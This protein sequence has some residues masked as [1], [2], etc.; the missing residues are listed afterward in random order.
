MLYEVITG[1]AQIKN[2]LLHILDTFVKNEY[3]V[4]VFPT[5]RRLDAYNIVKN[6]AGQYTLVVC[7]G[8][9]GTLN[10]TVKGLME[11]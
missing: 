8:G 3:E 4:T 1:R 7:C 9:D 5:Q 11:S 10:E 6:K 2:N